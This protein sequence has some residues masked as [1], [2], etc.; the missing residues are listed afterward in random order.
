MGKP[1]TL[2]DFACLSLQKM[3]DEEELWSIT[4][5]KHVQLWK[6][7]N[8]FQKEKKKDKIKDLPGPWQH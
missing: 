1:F 4:P 2:E 8:R 3:F 5:D 7:W 6:Y